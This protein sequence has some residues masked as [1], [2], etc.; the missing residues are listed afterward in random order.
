MRN[1]SNSEIQAISGGHPVVG[2]LAAGTVTSAI[3]MGWTA[4]VD[5]NSEKVT[6][7]KAGLIFTLG[8]ASAS[9]GIYIA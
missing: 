1:I 9:L 7:K 6:A 4:F 8:V 5:N 2:A 3:W